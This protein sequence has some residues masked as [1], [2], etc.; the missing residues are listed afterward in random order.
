M[1]ERSFVQRNKR[2]QLREVTE[3]VALRKE[4]AGGGPPG[5]GRPPEQI[6]PDVPESQ[7][8]AFEKAGWVFQEKAAEGARDAAP[9]AQVFVKSGGRLALGTNTLTVQIKGKPS[10]EEANA[11]LAPYGCR[12][13]ETLSF[14]PGLFRVAVVEPSEQDAL[15]AA[16][17]LSNSGLVEFAE[18][19]LIEVTGH[20]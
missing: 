4:D 5:G 10:E 19:E 18:P 7:V 11:A 15:D 1:R 13:V 2:V 20:R 12:V 3:L 8:R 17:R 16:D 14:A 6:A 9:G